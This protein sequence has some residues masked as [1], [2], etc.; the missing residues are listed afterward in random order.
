MSVLKKLFPFFL[1]TLIVLVG[2]QK[3]PYNFNDLPPTV[4]SFFKTSDTNF[5][6]DQEIKFTNGSENAV[7]YAWDFGDGTKSMD[8]DPVKVYATA[9]TFTVT[10][11]AVG[12]GGTGNY[13]SDFTI[14]DPTQ[15][16]KTD[17]Q[18]Y[19]IE[20]GTKL[21]KRISLEPGAAAEV[22]ANISGKVGVGLAYDSVN[23]K[24]YFTD[25]D[26]TDNGKVWRM[27]TTGTNMQ[28]IVAGITDPYSIVLNLAGGK[29]YWA[30]DAGN[31]S[32]ANLD[33]SGLEREFIHVADG[34]MRGIAYSAKKDMIF[35]YEVNDENLYAAK[36]DGT[37]VAKIITGTYG[38]G[39]FVDDVNGKLYYDDR[40][41]GGIMQADL[42]GSDPKK[43]AEAPGKTRIHGM[44]IDYTANKFYWADRD[45]GT[46]RRS[47]LD[48]TEMETFLSNLKSP[49]GIF[50]R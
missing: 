39:I 15:T 41:K 32:R 31:I 42:N 19:F 40:R 25:F 23:A 27:D 46:I 12:P 50:I 3:D 28:E 43:I 9:G 44:A 18:L 34:Q 8:K 45:I 21:I 5:D 47:N 49:R 37:G 38:Y 36:S 6:M 22:V 48:G 26:A 14:I 11:K 30:D 4:K 29:I 24:I 2:C 20:N 17:K 1:M 33:G 16:G 7:T 35:F 13:S 10:L